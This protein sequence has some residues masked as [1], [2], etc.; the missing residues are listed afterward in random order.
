M[1]SPNGLQSNLEDI[2]EA[3]AAGRLDHRNL[4]DG[5]SRLPLVERRHE[6]ELAA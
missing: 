1:Q 4:L 6:Q 2:G 5:G 3:I